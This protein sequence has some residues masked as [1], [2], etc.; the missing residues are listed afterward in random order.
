MKNAKLKIELQLRD[1][2]IKGTVVGIKVRNRSEVIATTVLN[3]DVVSANDNWIEIMP[4]TLYGHPVSET[5]IPMKDIKK[6]IPL[7]VHYDDPLYVRL[8]KIKANI[9]G[10]K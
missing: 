9:L 6:V 1:S 3:M 8:R 2:L 10:A 4:Y 7:S 5:R